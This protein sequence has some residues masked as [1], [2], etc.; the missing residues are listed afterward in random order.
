MGPHQRKH[1]TTPVSVEENG[2]HAASPITFN[3]S[4]GRSADISLHD[5][6]EGACLA[7]KTSE[8]VGLNSSALYQLTRNK[9]DSS[10]DS[11]LS[12]N[13]K[14]PDGLTG[15]K[16]DELSKSGVKGIFNHVVP[17]VSSH[18]FGA[19]FSNVPVSSSTMLS[20]NPLQA[21]PSTSYSFLS[22]TSSTLSSTESR[23][24]PY[25]TRAPT[26]SVLNTPPPNISLPPPPPLLNSNSSEPSLRNMSTVSEG[27]LSS[28]ISCSSSTA[29][30]QSANTAL[31]MKLASLQ[32]KASHPSFTVHH[33]PLPRSA[34]AQSAPLIPQSSSNTS[35]MWVTL[36]MQSPYAAHFSGV[37]PR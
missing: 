22:V 14:Q 23:V 34:L 8:M 31:A 17:S 15:A 27:Y 28:S 30:L 1:I 21:V 3:Y 32:L 16:G 33:P 36:G 5:Y 37:K 7:L 19:N 18:Q 4:S 9:A 10:I 35:A 11:N 6:N 12:S 26:P 13:K 20:F 29:S 25:L 2:C 24:A